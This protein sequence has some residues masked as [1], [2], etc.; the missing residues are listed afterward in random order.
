M[1]DTNTDTVQES[2]RSKA[3]S[4]T[5][6]GII[7]CQLKQAEELR[8]E[9]EMK[10]LHFVFNAE[11]KEPRRVDGPGTGLPWSGWQLKW[12]QEAVKLADEDLSCWNSAAVS[13]H[14]AR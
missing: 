7:F 11:I 6:C 14:R 3:L 13:D 1:S 8:K 2:P 12:L 4:N 5:F 9:Q 10:K